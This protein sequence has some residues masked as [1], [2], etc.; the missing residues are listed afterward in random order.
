[1]GRT[2]A[3]TAR[4]VEQTRQEMGAKVS[5]LAS[6]APQ[7]VRSLAKRVAFAVITSLAVLA[8]RKLLDKG[9]TRVTGELPP[10]KR[11]RGH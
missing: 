4:E 10:S 11:S 8:V 5:A 7:E 9:W 6:R 1:M 3:E 2:A